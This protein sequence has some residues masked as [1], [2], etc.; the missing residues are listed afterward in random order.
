[1]TEEPITHKDTS[2]ETV[3]GKKEIHTYTGTSYVIPDKH[4]EITTSTVNGIPTYHEHTV[5]T[6]DLP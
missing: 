2:T 4:S 1:M 3:D 5:T 6:Y